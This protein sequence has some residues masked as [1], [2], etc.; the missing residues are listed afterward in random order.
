[1][2]NFKKRANTVIIVILSLL[3]ST[4][5]IIASLKNNIKKN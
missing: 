5:G 1:M 2:S 3:S 4:R